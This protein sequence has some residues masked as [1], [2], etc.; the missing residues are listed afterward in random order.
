VT[1]CIGPAAFCLT[2]ISEETKGEEIAKAFIKAMGSDGGE[3]DCVLDDA[4]T[5]MLRLL[6]TEGCRVCNSNE[7]E[8]RRILSW[9]CPRQGWREQEP[10][11]ELKE[12]AVSKMTVE[13]AGDEIDEMEME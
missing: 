8:C 9:F 1:V 12:E 6:K 4:N 5:E 2:E 13:S 10:D 3:S 7:M 11:V